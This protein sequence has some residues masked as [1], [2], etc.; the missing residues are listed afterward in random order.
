MQSSLRYGFVYFLTLVVVLLS[1]WVEGWS[2]L[3]YLSKPL[4]MLI[5]M[6]MLW[7]HP[8][9]NK[10][11]VGVL[12]AALF[13]SWGGDV[14][15]MFESE[16]EL[17]F[18]FGL[19]SFLIAHICYIILFTKDAKLPWLKRNI[20]AAIPFL[21]YGVGL[22]SLLWPYLNE[23]K[24]PVLVYASSIMGMGLT[25]LNRKGN[26]SNSSFWMVFIGALLFV[27]SDSMIAINKF[28]EPIAYAQIWIMITYALSQWMIVKGWINGRVEKIK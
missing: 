10:M 2:S 28:Y 20:W 14:F 19:L 12:M 15:L 27:L 6:S 7:M 13:F 26:V 22:M 24:I 3:E 23:L 8:Q 9:R 5:L 18:I 4:L 17:F 21:L 11:G 16:H 25:A 1:R